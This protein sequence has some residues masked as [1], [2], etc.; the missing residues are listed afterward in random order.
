MRNDVIAIILNWN[1]ADD[2]IRCL[3][4]V[5]SGS[6][7]PQIIVVDNGSKDDS[8]E[9]LERL[10]EPFSL[11]R[12][13]HNAGYAGGMNAGIREARSRGAKWVWLLN[14]DCV[15][16]PEALTRLLERAD[17]FA[18]AA[19]LQTT[20]EH[21]DDAV[22]EPYLIAAMLPKGKVRPFRCS[23]CEQGEHQVDVVTGAALLLGMPWLDQVG[24][25]DERF[26][27]YK[28]EFDL[29]GR[30]RDAGGR[31]LLV[32]S[33]EV[34]HKRGGSLSGASP[35]ARYYHH[36]NEILYVRKHHSH[37]LRQ[38]LLNEPIHYKNVARSMLSIAF[39][40]Q[41]A[42][43]ASLAVLTGYWDGLRGVQG[44]TERY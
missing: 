35:L 32:C 30:I 27:H 13:D 3:R 9:R 12:L 34:W 7:A 41:R 25:F 20:S 23:G 33:S 19:S 31:V 18:V 28:E 6:T 39:G 26:F 29:V 22:S 14:A 36:R 8:V 42:R 44:P 10:D 21:P 1:C 37:P 38:I 24:L 4:A 2:T 5:A 16:R 15:P 43:R 11:V 40:G 17:H